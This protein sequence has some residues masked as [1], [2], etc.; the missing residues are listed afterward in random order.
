MTKFNIEKLVKE[1]QGCTAYLRLKKS[2]HDCI[3]KISLTNKMK[4]ST[5]IRLMIEHC[6]KELEGE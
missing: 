5:V 1:Y 6:V 3:K 4:I 2:D